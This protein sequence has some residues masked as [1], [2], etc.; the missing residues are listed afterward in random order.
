MGT[1]ALTTI[2]LAG[3]VIGAIGA[4]LL[5]HLFGQ[6]KTAASGELLSK[7][8]AKIAALKDL[9]ARN[10]ENEPAHVLAAANKIIAVAQAVAA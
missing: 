1:I 4:N 10:P 5:P 9:V 8:I 3:V 2:D 6:T 7:I